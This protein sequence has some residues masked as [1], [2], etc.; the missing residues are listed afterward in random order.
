MKSLDHENIINLIEIIDNPSCE[1]I[2]IVQEEAVGGQIS[3]LN[4][5]KFENNLDLLDP[6]NID[7]C[8][9]MKLR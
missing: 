8:N 9:E 4:D 2:Y 3:Y 6:D 1:K 5:N 7:T